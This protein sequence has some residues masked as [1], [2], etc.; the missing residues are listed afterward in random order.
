MPPHG[1]VEQTLLH[2]YSLF[3][4][5]ARKNISQI[6]RPFGNFS[7]MGLSETMTLLIP[8]KLFR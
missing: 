4:S 2:V 7:W 8:I 5:P 1:M 3:F 6:Q